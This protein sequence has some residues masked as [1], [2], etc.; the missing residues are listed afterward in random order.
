MKYIKK[1][2]SHTEYE[3]A[4]SSLTMPNVSCCVAQ[5]HVHYIS[6][7][8]EL[9]ISKNSISIPSSGGIDTVRIIS[10]F[11]NWSATTDKNWL[12]I[13][14]SSG[15]IGVSIA[16]ISVEE[17]NESRIGLVSF[18]DGITTQ[19]LVIEQEVEIPYATHYLT[20]DVISSGTI[21]WKSTGSLTK[22]IYYSLDDGETWSAITSTSEGV[23]INVTEGDKVLIKGNN[24]KYATDKSHYSG[25]ESGTALY[26]INGNIMSLVGGDNFSGLT[27]ISDTF[28]FCSLFKLSNAVSAKNLILPAQTLKEACYRAMF[29]KAHLLI[30]APELPATTLAKDCYWYMFEDCAISQAPELNATTLVQGS[31]GNMFTCCRNLNYIKCTA[32]GIT[33]SACTTNWVSGVSATGTFVKASS[34]SSWNRNNHGIPTGWT[35]YDNFFLF[36]PTI[37]CDGEI[38]T[39]SCKTEDAVIYYRTGE[40]DNFT[41]YTTQIPITGDTIVEAYSEKDGTQST[42]VIQNCS[43]DGTPLAA[44]TKSLNTWLYNG[45]EITVPYSVNAIDGHSSNYNKGNFQFETTVSLKHEQ[46]TYLWF[47][48]ADQ[49]ADIYVDDTKVTTHWGG[50]NAFFTDITN[51][52][53]SGTNNVKVTL[54]NTTRNALAPCTGD[55]NFNATLGYVKLLTSP[56]LPD[57]VYGYDGFHV[58]SIVTSSAD[59]ATI[60]VKTSIPVGAEVVCSIDD[61]NYHFTETKNS[62][63]EEMSFSAIV[64]N[65][66]LWDGTIN[67]HL[68][69]IKLEIYHNGDLYHVFERPYGLRYYDYVFNDTN[70]LPNN[71]PYTGFLLNGKPYLLR[72]VCMHSD[73]EGKANALTSTDID[74]DFNIIQELGCNF[75]RLAHYPHP[76]EVYDKCD[77]LGIIVQTEVPLVNNFNSAQPSDYYT[78]L[79]GQYE[80][81]VNQHY[82][83]PCIMF[84]G[85]FNEA[86]TDDK[87]FAKTKIEEYKALIKNLDSERLVGYVVS[88]SYSNPSSVFNNPDVDWFGCNIYVGWYIDQASNDPTS[89][90]NT[91]TGNTIASLGK[92]LAFSEYGCGGTQHC[93]SEDPQ[94]TTTKGNYA[95]HDIE[96]HMWLHEG[97]ISAIR[98][99]P[100]LL[101]TAEWQLF[102]IAVSKRNEGYTICLDGENT[103]ID[104]NLRYL[105]DKGLVE[106]DHITKKD[107][108]YLYKAEWNPEKFVHIC[109]KDYTRKE[110]RVIKC[111]TTEENTLTM[112]V[113]GT[114]R[115]TASISNHM[116]SFSA[117]TFNSGD[118]V[119]VSG[120]TTNDTFTFE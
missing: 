56:V 30:E 61:E 116:A 89:Q 96:Y 21:N 6:Q 54:C 37:Y 69:N 94:T 118:V 91:R 93:H 57:V 63:G 18:T 92:A 29:S 80:D 67:P 103:S 113:N 108:F 115:G 77:Q 64:Q 72:G 110:N 8:S 111:Y 26:N 62:T 41:Q 5:H 7:P 102:D 60:Y 3:Q 28:A 105:N 81:M 119:I 120:A 25:F 38:V 79:T 70:V 4:E 74:N 50:Y 83:H 46:P 13:T 76:K 48:H 40:T 24:T 51:Y 114:Q 19:P 12:T 10:P 52:I 104:N 35:I 78:H 101:F 66:T 58:S 23:P 42:T 49:S 85:L 59:P 43:Y 33:A 98:N 99:F 2:N 73:L 9:Q 65:P 84:W 86:T 47:Q 15:Q 95:R 88:H 11:N 109:C 45:N 75:I 112:Y 87:A 31:Y 71:D 106:R 53:H 100:Q 27:S 82:N 36:A 32:T 55:F 34:M 16:E 20:F 39:I 68:Y 1:F 17:A 14:P 97:H 22:T 90:L 107:T 117:T 44:S